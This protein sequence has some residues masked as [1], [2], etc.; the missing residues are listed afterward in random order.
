MAFKKCP[1]VSLLY[2]DTDSFIQEHFC[3]D[4]IAEYKKMDKHFNFSNYPRDIQQ[5]TRKFLDT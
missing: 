1:E 4:I 5:I 2:S 3:D